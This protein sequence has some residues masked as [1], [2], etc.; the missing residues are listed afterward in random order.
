MLYICIEEKGCWEKVGEGGGDLNTRGC[1]AFT[2]AVSLLLTIYAQNSS[3]RE[4]SRFTFIP[5]TSFSQAIHSLRDFFIGHLYTISIRFSTSS[6]LQLVFSPFIPRLHW[7]Q[8]LQ[9]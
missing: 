9:S 6:S 4:A 7:M 2:V 1:S 5:Q 3:S 8:L